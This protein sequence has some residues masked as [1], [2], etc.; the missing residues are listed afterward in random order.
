MWL[1]IILFFIV[2]I[3]AFGML[4][5]RTWELKTSQIE[6]PENERKLMPEIYFRQVEK[7]VLYL[8]KHVIQ[9][10]VL[11]IVKY[12][13]ISTTKAKKWIGKNYPKITKI[14]RKKESTGE[15]KKISF[16]KRARLELKAKIGRIK[17][18][19]KREHGN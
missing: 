15:N 4:S 19:V 7:V 9:W 2:I 3:S 8:A 14:F 11:A 18:K 16:S 12:W 10:I 5:F 13:F 1:I 6:K 17:E